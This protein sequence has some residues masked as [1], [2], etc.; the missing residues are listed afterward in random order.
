MRFG[1][2]ACASI[3]GPIAPRSR[4]SS[5]LADLDRALRV[6]DRDVLEGPLAPAALSVPRPSG[7][8][9]GKSFELVL[10]RPIATEQVRSEVIVGVTGPA[11]VRIEKVSSP[12]QPCRRR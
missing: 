3:P 2:S 5:S 12:V 6:A 10:A 4:S 9:S 8:P 1:K 7:P 11:A